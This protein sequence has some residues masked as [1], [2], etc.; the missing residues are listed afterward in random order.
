MVRSVLTMQSMQCD[1]KCSY[2]AKYE[3]GGLETEPANRSQTTHSR[4]HGNNRTFMKMI[5]IECGFE[6]QKT[7]MWT[8]MRIMCINSCKEEWGTHFEGKEASI[9]CSMHLVWHTCPPSSSP[10]L[11]KSTCVCHLPA[12]FYLENSIQ[13]PKLDCNKASCIWSFIHG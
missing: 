13:V 9:L 12:R 5:L 2:N 8:S 4:A 10:K 7:T 6:D 11:D 3:G 1:Q